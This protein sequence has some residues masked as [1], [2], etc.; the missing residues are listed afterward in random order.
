M[1]AEIRTIDRMAQFDRAEIIMWKGELCRCPNIGDH[2][3]FKV[4]DEILCRQIVN[5]AHDIPRGMVILFVGSKSESDI[6]EQNCRDF[7]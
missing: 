3:R 6:T 2:I 1:V 5:I 7:T 4:K